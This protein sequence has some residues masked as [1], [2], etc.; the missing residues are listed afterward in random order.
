MGSL[1]HHIPATLLVLCTVYASSVFF[2]HL[3]HVHSLGRDQPVMYWF[4]GLGRTMLT[5]FQCIAGGVSW[6]EVVG[7]MFSEVSP[8]IAVL[9]CFYVYIGMVWTLNLITGII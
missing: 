4:H 7:P 5:M 6:N 8:V 2:L 9:F 3:L 1:R